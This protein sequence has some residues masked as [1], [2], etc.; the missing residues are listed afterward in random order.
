MLT[1]I[2]FSLDARQLDVGVEGGVQVGQSLRV[3]ALPQTCHHGLLGQHGL[4]CFAAGV[5]DG[6]QLD[7]LVHRFQFTQRVHLEDNENCD[8]W[9]RERP[10]RKRVLVNNSADEEAEG[11]LERSDH[12]QQFRGQRAGSQPC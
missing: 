2:R 3:A 4:L 10:H 1:R 6:S 9:L 12:D 5:L 11:R 7:E 8:Q